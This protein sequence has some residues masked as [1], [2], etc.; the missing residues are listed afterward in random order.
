MREIDCRLSHCA[1]WHF[2]R[3][4]G[5]D[6]GAHAKIQDRDLGGGDAKSFCLRP[7]QRHALEFAVLVAFTVA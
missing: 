3:H 5:G 2:V 1:Y 4:V 7:E 6:I